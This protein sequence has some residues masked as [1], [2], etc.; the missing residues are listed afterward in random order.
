MYEQMKMRK[1]EREMR[2]GGRKE[3]KKGGIVT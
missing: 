3:K 2:E 1:G